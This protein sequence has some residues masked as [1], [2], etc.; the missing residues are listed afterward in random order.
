MEENN[1]N[2]EEIERGRKGEGGKERGTRRGREREKERK[3]Q[4]E[5]TRIHRCTPS[6]TFTPLLSSGSC[7]HTAIECTRESSHVVPRCIGPIYERGLLPLASP[8]PPPASPLWAPQERRVL[9]TRRGVSAE[10]I[11]TKAWQVTTHTSLCQRSDDLRGVA[12]IKYIYRGMKCGRL[13][14]DETR[15]H[16]QY[17]REIF[18]L[19]PAV[20]APGCIQTHG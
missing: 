7:V 4:S 14:W 18:F 9:C 11:R 10:Y 12:L 5:R 1:E 2:V 17:K 20:G 16:C 3:G 15:K 8:P 6:S 13:C 19:Y